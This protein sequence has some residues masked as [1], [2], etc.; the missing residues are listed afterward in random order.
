[1][2]FLNNVFKRFSLVDL[3]K[4]A[5][6]VFLGYFLLLFSY[7]TP[8]NRKKWAF[9]NKM[10]FKDNTKY[11]FLYLLE[12][13]KDII[14]IWISSSRKLVEELKAYSYPVYYKYSLKGLYHSLTAGVYISTVNTNH[15]NYF[16]SG[17]VF[18]VYLWHGIALKSMPDAKSMPW[19]KSILSR[20]CMP[21][22]YEKI[23]FFLS[24]TP[25]IDEQF[26]ITFNVSEKALYSGMYPRCSFMLR[27]KVSLLQYIRSSENKLMSD[28]LEKMS[29]YNKVYVYMP[30]WRIEYGSRFLE[31]AMPDLNALNKVL[32]KK[33]ILLLLKLHPSMQYDSFK[34]KDL[35]NIYYIDA[36]IDMYPLLPFSDVLISD[37]SSIYYDYL[38]LPNKGVILYDFDVDTYVKNE[39]GFFKDYKTYTPGKHVSDFNSLLTILDSNESFQISEK[40]R[41]WILHEMW[42]NFE[43]KNTRDLVDEIIKR[44]LKDY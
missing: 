10:N 8:R 42:G 16:T 23:D 37:Y 1:M 18:N 26:L 22:A 25:M 30:T 35:N 38:L 17:R 13:N 11:L 24:T 33:N 32:E 36:T 14:P 7:L 39:F 12:N 27:D 29:D 3:F 6:R 2:S 20:I 40:E 28:I 4:E 41:L 21:Y 34:Y 44:S 19:D 43:H 9:G 15:I 31:Y 5:I